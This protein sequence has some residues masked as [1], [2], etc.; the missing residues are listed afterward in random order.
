MESVNMTF[1]E[2]KEKKEGFLRRSPTRIKEKKGCF[3]T[4]TGK[5]ELY[6]DY[7]NS[8]GD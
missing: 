7:L 6:A 4:P 5:V 2:F 8:M 1:A 3:R